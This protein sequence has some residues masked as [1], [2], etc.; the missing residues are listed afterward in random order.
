MRQNIYDLPSGKRYC[1]SCKSINCEHTHPHISDGT[2]KNQKEKPITHVSGGRVGSDSIFYNPHNARFYFRFNRWSFRESVDFK[3]LNSGSEFVLES[4]EG[5]RIAVKRTMVEVT[6]K[7][8]SLRLFPI[9]GT[10]D[11]R[12]ELTEGAKLTLRNEAINALKEFI[13]IYGGVSD[14]VCVKEWIPDNKAS[15]HP[16]IESIPKGVTWRDDVSKRVYPDKRVI[17]YATPELAQN[18]FRNLGIV[19]VAPLIEERLSKIEDERSSFNS[20][21]AK[22][23]EQIELH[24]KVEERQLKVQ[25]ETLLTLKAIQESVKQS[26]YDKV[27]KLK[28][29]W[30]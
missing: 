1:S 16:V 27:R 10:V 22:Y 13:R 8:D 17:E 19:D 18:A 21:L 23:T 29:D 12:K 28:E 9:Q 20:A 30:W 26:K 3:S 6:N 4:F 11:E 24:L 7:V 2:I 25:D 15:H 14:F 5:C